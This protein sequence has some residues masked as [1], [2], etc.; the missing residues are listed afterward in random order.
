M[1]D[2]SRGIVI[3]TTNHTRV[4]DSKILSRLLVNAVSSLARAKL[5]LHFRVGGQGVLAELLKISKVTK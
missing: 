1:Y 3:A 5:V 2:C 4:T